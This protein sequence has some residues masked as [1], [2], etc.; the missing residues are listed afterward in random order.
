[1]NRGA[2]QPRFFAR[3]RPLTAGRL[4]LT[5][6]SRGV[7]Q[8]GSPPPAFGTQGGESEV[9][10]LSPDHSFRRPGRGWPPL[11]RRIKGVRATLSIMAK[12]I[13][14]S[15]AAARLL[16]PEELSAGVLS[17][18][19]RLRR[20]PA[21]RAW[22]SAPC[23]ACTCRAARGSPRR[24]APTARPSTSASTSRSAVPDE[25]GRRAPTVDVDSG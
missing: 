1:M 4:P 2:A 20:R 6:S 5:V 14:L 13:L 21:Q 24:A 9:Q 18:G 11:S 19:S 15:R 25:F 16:D 22:C 10:I 12:I 7:A 17:A 3:S 8:P 23:A